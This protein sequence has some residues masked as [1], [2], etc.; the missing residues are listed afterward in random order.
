M[1]DEHQNPDATPEDAEGSPPEGN[2]DDPGGRADDEA[3]EELRKARSEARSLRQRLKDAEKRLTEREK[4]EMSDLERASAEIQAR[5]ERLASLQS[6]YRNLRVQLAATRSGVRPDAV[7]AAA[8]LVDWDEL[9]ETPDDKALDAHMRQV[10]K[11]NPYLRAAS[12]GFDGGEGNDQPDSSRTKSD[13]G[14]LIRAA[15]QGR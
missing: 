4:S 7:R 10:V 9:G 14:S 6:E 8:A 12:G 13:I 5:D 3:R 1:A 11:E 15:R 2:G